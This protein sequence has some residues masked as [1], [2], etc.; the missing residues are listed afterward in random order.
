MSWVCR[1]STSV[2]Q[3]VR[4]LGVP[5]VDVDVIEG[6]G[7]AGHGYLLCLLLWRID[8][9]LAQGVVGQHQRGHRLDHR[10]RARQHA[11]VVAAAALDGRVL[12]WRR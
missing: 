12:P 3:L 10:H 1:P 6:D 9:L 4:A 2:Y 11:G 7:L 8:R 5:D